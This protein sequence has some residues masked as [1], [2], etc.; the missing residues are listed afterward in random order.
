MIETHLKV[1]HLGRITRLLG[2]HRQNNRSQESDFRIVGWN[3]DRIGS[4]HQWLCGHF[5]SRRDWSRGAQRG[6]QCRV[7]RA[8]VRQR[9]HVAE[10]VQRSKF[11]GLKCGKIRNLLLESGKDFYPL[12]RIDAQIVI[13]THVE[14]E[15][16][17]RVTCLFGDDR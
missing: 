3:S 9:D 11:V 1:D 8:G 2:N 15:H 17:G 5:H 16:L 12:D 7:F 6:S 4:G 14:I 13:K 10:C